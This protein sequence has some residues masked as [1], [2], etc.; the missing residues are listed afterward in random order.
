MTR[1]QQ[2]SLDDI[3]LSTHRGGPDTEIAAAIDNAARSPKQRAQVLDALRKAGNEGRTD[4][5]LGV[6]LGIL[7]TSAGKRRLELQRIGLV[8]DSG[9]R[10]PTDTGSSGVV[11]RAVAEYP[12][13]SEDVRVGGRL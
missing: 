2:L 9:E 3:K 7:R 4:Y 5:E 12:R 13:W 11:W 8:V 6:E 10:R 1:G